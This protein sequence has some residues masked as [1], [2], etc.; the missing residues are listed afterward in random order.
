MSGRMCPR[1]T[2]NSGNG[3]QINALLT[4]GYRTN[5]TTINKP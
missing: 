2:D 5:G 3:H 4:N 1:K